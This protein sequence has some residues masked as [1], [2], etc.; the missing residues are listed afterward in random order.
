MAR[1]KGGPKNALPV[2]FDR[3]LLQ[4]NVFVRA[5]SPIATP[6]DLVGKRV[7]SRLS[8]QS[9]T[10]AGVLMMLEQGY[11]VPLKEVKWSIG[12]RD[13]GNPNG[14]GLDVTAGPDTDQ[15]NLELLRPGSAGR[16]DLEPGRPLLVDVR[17]RTCSTTRPCCRAGLARW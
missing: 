7:G 9:G 2:F 11:G 16:G 13:L 1:L 8:L 4:R 12:G 14:M 15:G 5:D 17:R 10:F 6:R 3:E